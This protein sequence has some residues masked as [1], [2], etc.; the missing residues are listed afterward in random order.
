MNSIGKLIKFERIKQNM[1]QKSLCHGIC[2]NT[3]LSKIE[4]SQISTSE[5]ILALLVDA[6]GY[7]YNEGN[8]EQF[9]E[10]NDTVW[11]LYFNNFHVDYDFNEQERLMLDDLY[12]SSVSEEVLLLSALVDL[13]NQRDIDQSYFDIIDEK[14]LESSHLYKHLIILCLNNK[15]NVFTN[16]SLINY[17]DDRGYIT[18]YK[19]SA[20]FIKG[21]Y[22]DSLKYSKL[23]YAMFSDQGKIN[24][25]ISSS[26]YEGG[27][28][29]N[30]NNFESFVKVN[31][32]IISLNSSHYYVD[33]DINN[34]LD[35]NLGA[36]YLMMKDYDLA[37][38]HLLKSFNE[39]SYYRNLNLEKLSFAY[40]FKSDFI[41]AKDHI[42]KL[43]GDV[44]YDVIKYLLDSQNNIR[45]KDYVNLLESTYN[46][47]VEEH[48][49]RSILYKQLLMEAYKVNYMY[50]R[51]LKLYE[52]DNKQE[53]Q[54]YF[55]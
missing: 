49:G 36:T 43:E 38:E 40:L 9:K 6:L 11:D 14:L 17:Q 50:P 34:M 39:D 8:I 22:F 1:S 7:K 33:K 4:L 2:S 52:D 26:F 42:D 20:S 13:L 12:L 18:Y 47:I 28:Y 29:S 37:I 54:S 5:E 27:S 51:A 10:L 3:Y 24:W 15:E 46:K 55:K 16:L 35:Y 21:N 48:H 53:N 32:R 19:A 45:S 30:L 31:K 44:S 41:G 23:A 25:M